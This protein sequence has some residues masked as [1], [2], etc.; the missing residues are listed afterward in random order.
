MTLPSGNDCYIAMEAMALIEIDGLPFLKMVNNNGYVTN[1]QMMVT[2]KYYN[3]YWTWW[4]SSWIYPLKMVIFQITRPGKCP[5]TL[6]QTPSIH[7][8]DVVTNLTAAE[9]AAGWWGQSSS[10]A[11]YVGRTLRFGYGSIPMKIPFLGGWTSILTQLNFDVNRRGTIGFDTLP[12]EDQH[13][14]MVDE[15]NKKS[16]HR[17]RMIRMGNSARRSM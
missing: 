3:S 13:E 14:I 1:N 9:T 7:R 17:K 4:F 16:D 5:G 8:Q 12:F 10:R 2:N 6:S 15:T 11:L